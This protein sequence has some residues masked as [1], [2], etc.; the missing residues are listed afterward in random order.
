[1]MRPGDIL[2]AIRE[3][4]PQT[5]MMP[6]DHAVAFVRRVRAS[7]AEYIRAIERTNN[8]QDRAYS[9][10]RDRGRGWKSIL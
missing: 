7:N 2:R 3:Q 8:E 9:E 10:W 4:F 1:M 5:R 6:D